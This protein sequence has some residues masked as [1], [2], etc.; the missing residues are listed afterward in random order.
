MAE[1]GGRKG[2]TLKGALVGL[3]AMLP[4][5]LHDVTIRYLGGG[6]S[7]FQP[8][9][10]AGLVPVPL[11]LGQLWLTGTAGL[12]PIL[13]GFMALQALIAVISA[14]S[15]PMPSRTCPWRRPIRSS[16]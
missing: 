6:Y 4:F 14:C 13:P 15:G 9:S 11:I 5:C 12:R 8:V 7:P 2:N 16:S 3:A 1:A 10:C